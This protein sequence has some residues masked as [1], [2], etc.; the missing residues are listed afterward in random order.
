MQYLIDTNIFLNVLTE[1][2]KKKYIDCVELLTKIKTGKIS[3]VTSSIILA[4]IVWTLKATYKQTKKQRVR[5]IKSIINLKNL[6]IVDDYNCAY[7][8]SLHEKH[9]I[10]FVDSLIASIAGVSEKKI[11]VISYDKEFDKVNVDRKEPRQI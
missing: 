10:K 4:E 9:K 2:N 5:A 11:A 1:R 6:K 8:L 7:A 3:G